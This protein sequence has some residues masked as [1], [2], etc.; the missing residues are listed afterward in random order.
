MRRTKEQAAQTSKQILLA[1]ENLFLERGYE[2]V[3]LE[4]IASAAG[5][6]RGAVHWHYKN[7]Q[8]LLFAIRAAVQEPFSDLA[9]T[10]SASQ[11]SA[12][13]D[14]LT[15]IVCD[16]FSRI[17]EDPRQ[18]GLCLVVLH[19]DIA[20]SAETSEGSSFQVDMRSTL[21]RIFSAIDRDGGLSKEWPPSKAA[22]SLT[23]TIGGLVM[24]WALGRQDFKLSG[25]GVDLIRTILGAWRP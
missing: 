5:V 11:G 10:L 18:R 3:S 7:K 9:E 25:D 15:S 14:K 12:S 4:E 6:T 8:G 21:E 2:N 16:M 1:A 23:A 17:D 20:Q 13:L 24:E 19:L 22:I